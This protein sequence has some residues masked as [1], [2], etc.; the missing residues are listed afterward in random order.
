MLRKG[1]FAKV[2]GKEYRLT[3]YQ[4]QYYLR[5]KNIEDLQLGFIEIQGAA[6]EYIKEINKEDLEDAYEIFPY[7]MLRGYRF[8]IEGYNE[9][10]GLVGLVT[11]NPFVQDK[12]DVRAYRKDE[13]IIELPYEQVLIEEDR[14]PI[15]GF[16]NIDYRK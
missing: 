1:C 13:Y 16:E 3:S 5:S 14:I 11:S 2:N 4:R 7:A 8:A 12:I 9:K 15:L 6:K 10:T